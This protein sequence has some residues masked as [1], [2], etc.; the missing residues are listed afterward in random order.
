LGGWLGGHLV[1]GLGVGVDTTIFQQGPEDW[2]YVALEAEVPVD[3]LTLC[4]AD[5]LALV[6]IKL[7]GGRI[8]AYADRC[9]HRGA[10]LHE[11]ELVDGSI[12]C[13]WHGCQFSVDDGSIVRGPATRPQPAYEVRLTDGR[14]EV[15]RSDEV[16][17]LRTSRVV[18][19]A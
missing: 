5:G 6:L 7:T 9:T 18:E 4:A 13:P 10:P 11:G 2:T 19:R 15:R 1:Y 12:T 14:V 8:V 17:A 16:R 3:Q